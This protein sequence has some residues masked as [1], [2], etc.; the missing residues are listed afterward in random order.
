MST[1]LL[2]PL[3][4]RPAVRPDPARADR[5]FDLRR[6]LQAPLRDWSG[7][8]APTK[9]ENAPPPLTFESAIV[10]HL[11]AAKRLARAL[12]RDPVLADDVVQD[13]SLKAWRHLSSL[14]GGDARP[15]L[16]RI[17]RNAAF[18]LM[19]GRRGETQTPI[20]DDIDAV[21]N[22]PDIGPSPEEELLRD[23][24]SAQLAGAVQRLPPH[25]RPCVELRVVQNMAYKD[26][27][28]A[29]GLPLGTVMSRLHRARKHMVASAA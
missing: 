18:D 11:G 12:T 8:P 14:Q 27:A 16:L 3:P 10:P 22:V 1:N 2:Q 13:A 26:I 23:E 19:R 4:V 5:F 20:D 17:V 25:L 24:A 29:L 9:P 28:T 6:R 15:W 7:L 21:L